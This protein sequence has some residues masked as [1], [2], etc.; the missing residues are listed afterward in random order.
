MSTGEGF[1]ADRG[2]AASTGSLGQVVAV[3]GSEA[4]VGLALP[5]PQGAQRATVGKFVSIGGHNTKLVGMISE[6]RARSE[7]PNGT[8]AIARVD[9][10]GEIEQ[11]PAGRRRFRRGVR[12]YAAIGDPVELIGHD[13]LNLIYAASGDRAI[14]VGHLSQDPTIPAYV[15]TDHMLAKHFAVVG[16]TGVG[17]SSAVSAILSRMIDVRPELRVLLLDVHN[18]YRSAFGSRANVVGAE[19]LRLPFWMFSFEE[20]L[21]VLYAGKPA[22]QEE[23]EIL[24]ELIPVARAKYQSGTERVAVE[25]R[26]MPRHSGFTADTPSPYHLQDLL[27]LISERM[28]KLENRSSGMSHHRLMTRIDA[29]KTDPRYEFMFKSAHLGGDT[30]VAVLSQVFSLESEDRPLTIL[31]LAS[32]PDEVVDAVVCVLARLA[33][34]FSLWS[35]GAIPILL[36]C[37]EAHRYASADRH[38]GFAPARRALKR[39]AREGRKYGVHL[40]LVTQRPAEL[41]PTIISQCST[42]FVMRMTNDADQA[43]LRSAVSDAAA[44]LLGFVPSLGVQEAIGIGEGL[45]LVA[46]IT[47][48]TLP[49]DSIPRSESGARGET[50]RPAS[51]SEVVRSA[52]ERWRR[53]TTNSSLRGEQE[54]VPAVDPARSAPVGQT[55]PS[56]RLAGFSAE[57]QNLAGHVPLDPGQ[58]TPSL[59]R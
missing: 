16:S 11:S 17:K 49:G 30:M 2:L 39:I 46:R 33:F 25:R 44:N 19:N 20:I 57:G 24:A 41:D 48:D 40:G 7:E 14:T 54:P 13:E 5:L 4:R 22:A 26:Q 3:E 37:E 34:D 58:N 50:E 59:R 1:A 21:N 23:V 9:L 27:A 55:A 31:K 15:D 51:R 47:F 10:L 43:L 42:F 18:E 12:E 38:S 8:G 53:A 52:I 28:G 6:V 56:L 45:P 36:V 29:I 32:L 35:D